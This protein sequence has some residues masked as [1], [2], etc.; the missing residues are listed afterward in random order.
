MNDGDY[1]EEELHGAVEEAYIDL[2]YGTSL[3]RSEYGICCP[4][5]VD[6]DDAEAFDATFPPKKKQKLPGQLFD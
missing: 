1:L 6:P 5:Y 3:T 2:T 4:F